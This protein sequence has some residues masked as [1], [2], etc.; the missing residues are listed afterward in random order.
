MMVDASGRSSLS[1][2]PKC[3]VVICVLAYGTSVD[4]TDYYLRIYETTTLKC[5]YKF[6]RGVINIFGA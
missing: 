6:T 1:P 4:S 3:T 5:V 2:L